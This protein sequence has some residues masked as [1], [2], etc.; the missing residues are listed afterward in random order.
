[1]NRRG[2][3]ALSILV[4]I[5]ILVLLWPLEGSIEKQL[6]EMRPH[7]QQVQLGGELPGIYRFL[8]L[9]G[10]NALLADLLWMKA[11]DLWHSSS[12]WQMA[13]VLEAVVRVDPNYIVACRILAWHYGWNLHTAAQTAVERK[14]WLQKAADTYERVVRDNPDDYTLWLDK[15]WFYAD[16]T[17]QYDK[18][19]ESL[20]EATKRFPE[21]IDTL[22]RRLQK[23]YEKTWRVKDAVRVIKGIIRKRPSDALARRDLEWW[24]NLGEDVNWRWVLEFREHVSRAGRNLP[25]YR[26]PFEGTLV[27]SPPWRDWEQNVMYMDPAWQPDLTGF[28]YES[29][30]WIFPH[31]PDLAEEYAKAHPEVGEIKPPETGIPSEAPMVQPGPPGGPGGPFG[32]P[33]GGAGPGAHGTHDHS[34]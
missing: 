21:Q 1:M 30:F 3:A 31:R 12:W 24:E 33:P 20:E 34:H 9:A 32:G 8:Q 27:D 10:L 22:D 26:N 17:R 28:A 19:I 18:A 23:M 7:R 14:M 29:V 11:D 15:C 5:C 25:P 2:P 16:R 4:V 13:P 6:T